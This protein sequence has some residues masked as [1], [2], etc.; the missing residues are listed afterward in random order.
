[1]RKRTYCAIIGDINKSRDL[2]GRAKIQTRFLSTIDQLNREFRNEI[3][4][5]FRFKVSEGDS[6]E[7][8]LVSSAESYRFAR[9]LQDLMAP[10]PFA[11]GIGIGPLSTRIANRR[12]RARLP[13]DTL[14]GE[15]FY[16]AR[17]ALALAKSTRQEVVFD[18]DSPALQQTNALVGLMESEWDRLT[19]RQRELIRRR[20][21]LG[22]Q[23]A[24][25]K[26]LKITQ[27]AVSKV[28]GSPTVRKMAQ[29]EKALHE[30]LSLLSPPAQI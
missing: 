27:P 17:R 20:K 15:A 4:S 5:E 9:R 11:I 21:E 28:L 6:F 8:L 12:K 19:P 14:D 13:V 25:A 16:R 24:V 29:A 2:L 10:I 7:G 22:S 1:M 26:R 30:F 18:F 23:A 3:V